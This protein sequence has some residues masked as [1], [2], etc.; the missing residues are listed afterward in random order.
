MSAVKG[1]FSSVWSYGVTFPLYLIWSALAGIA[2]GLVPRV[3]PL[4]EN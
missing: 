4:T 3:L 1:F 2:N